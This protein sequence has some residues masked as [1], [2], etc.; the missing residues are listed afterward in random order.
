VITGLAED[1]DLPGKSC[2][3]FK[4]SS[5]DKCIRDCN[6]KGFNGGSCTGVSPWMIVCCCNK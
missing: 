2:E 5:N 3:N 1:W 6:R 4:C